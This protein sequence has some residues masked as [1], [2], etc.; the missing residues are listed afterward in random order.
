MATET[1]ATATRTTTVKIATCLMVG[2]WTFFNSPQTPLKKPPILAV[3][4]TLFALEAE[5]EV[6]KFF[7]SLNLNIRGGPCAFPAHAAPRREMQKRG[8]PPSRLFRFFVF[9]VRPAKAAV[10]TERYAVRS[11]LFVLVCHIVT[12]LALSASQS[13]RHAHRRRLL[14]RVRPPKRGTFLGYHI[15]FALSSIILATSDEFLKVF[16]DA[17]P[18]CE[19]F[20]PL[21]GREGAGFNNYNRMVL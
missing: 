5:P 14:N 12:P 1:T 6:A 20:F 7:T 21:P 4:F 16:Y 10:F 11:G 9:G 19:N 3:I 13:N 17:K 8:P 2:Q 18:A 15:P